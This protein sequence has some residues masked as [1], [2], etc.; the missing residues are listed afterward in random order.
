MLLVT[1]MWKIQSY[2]FCEARNSNVA[3]YCCQ[4]VISNNV[5][6]ERVT[7]NE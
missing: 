1:F 6:F 2:N 4:K 7:S 3:N 5:T